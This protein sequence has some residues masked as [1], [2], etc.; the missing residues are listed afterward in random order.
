MRI[1]TWNVV[2]LPNCISK[3]K[4]SLEERLLKIIN[5]ILE[6]YSYCDVLLLN[7]VFLK[8]DLFIQTLKEVWPH[9]VKGPSKW[10]KLFNSGL[11]TFSK[12]PIQFV[13]TELFKNYKGWDYFTAKGFIAVQVK[14]TLI[15][16]TH[17]QQGDRDGENEARNKQSLQLASYIRKIN[18]P[19]VLGGDLNMGID[20]V[21]VEN[22]QTLVRAGE[23]I[24]PTYSRPLEETDKYIVRF[25]VKG[26]KP[27]NTMVV[28]RGMDR[29][30]SDTSPLFF[31]FIG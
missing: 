12:F 3:F 8:Q 7:E 25:L 28:E 22:Y 9:Y 6:K 24:E 11:L 23:L 30:I 1:V 2:S 31:D 16:N 27:E 15:I 10:F 26:I 20:D 13:Y 5:V 19:V 21:R 17:M 29:S 14:G 4:G 18:I